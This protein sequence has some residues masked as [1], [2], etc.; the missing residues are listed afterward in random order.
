MDCLLRAVTIRP[1]W[2]VSAQKL[3]APKQPRTEAME[4][5]TSS[6]AGMPPS[7]SYIGW[8]ARM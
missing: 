8:Y 4:N 7:F 1:W 6:M 3:H 5:L 2:K